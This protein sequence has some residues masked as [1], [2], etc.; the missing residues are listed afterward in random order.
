VAA[1]FDAENIA[2]EVNTS[3]ETYRIYLTLL[4]SIAT[5]G[6][7]QQLLAAAWHPASFHPC[8]PRISKNSIALYQSSAKAFFFA[9]FPAALWD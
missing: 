9:A 8:K 2:V 5:A 6:M 7:Q 3:R 4:C 1:R